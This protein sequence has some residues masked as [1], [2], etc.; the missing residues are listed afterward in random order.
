MRKED[1]YPLWSEDRVVE[2]LSDNHYFVIE[3]RDNNN[4]SIALQEGTGNG[5][6][7]FRQYVD[8]AMMEPDHFRMVL[9]HFLRDSTDRRMHEQFTTPN[10]VDRLCKYKTELE[11]RKMARLCQ[12]NLH[13]GCVIN[14]PKHYHMEGPY[15]FECEGWAL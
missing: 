7:T 5:H 15:S 8:Q 11:Q 1:D 10:I 2:K 14:H 6:Y 3:I 13:C 9:E 4:A 12:G